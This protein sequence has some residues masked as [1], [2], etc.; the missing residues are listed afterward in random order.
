MTKTEPVKQKSSNEL[1]GD[2]LEYQMQFISWSPLAIADYGFE[3]YYIGSES[4]R[5]MEDQMEKTRAYR[6]IVDGKIQAKPSAMLSTKSCES[7]GS[8]KT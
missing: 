4:G 7:G 1:D 8:Y 2:D 6:A 3:K 5:C